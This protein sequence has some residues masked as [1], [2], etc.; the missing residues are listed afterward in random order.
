MVVAITI[1]IFILGLFLV[2]KL[3]GSLSRAVLGY[4]SLGTAS[5]GYSDAERQ[6]L[7]DLFFNTVFMLLGHVSNADNHV[8]E[9]EIRLT[10]SYMEKMGLSTGRKIEAM[11]LFKK[12]AEAGFDLSHTLH[13]FCFLVKKSPD[14]TEI[15]LVYL[16]NLARMDGVLYP[17][18]IA[19][20]HRVGNSLGFSSYAFEHLLRMIA[21]QNR[22]APNAK[23]Q[24]RTS[25]DASAKSKTQT[26][27]ETPPLHKD[28]VT[29]YEALGVSPEATDEE[30]K[31]A[32]R[33][34]M[35]QFHPDKLMGQGVPEFMIKDA[36]EHSMKIQ[37]AYDTIKKFRG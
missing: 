16:V 23:S 17:T 20:L 7:H 25:G 24:Q 31:K 1:I 22:F 10:E 4:L 30:V 3:G 34:L 14:L 5:S 21:S 36:T 37:A 33:K 12:G 13:E 28:V 6:S 27:T 15:L 18:E 8:Q 2:Y 11:R 32:Y 19:T 9:V 29:A 26:E 35:S